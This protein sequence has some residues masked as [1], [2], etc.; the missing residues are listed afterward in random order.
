M[1]T[2]IRRHANIR[3]RARAYTHM[4][5]L[6]GV[7]PNVRRLIWKHG[8]LLICLVIPCLTMWL[9]KKPRSVMSLPPA[10]MYLDADIQNI[11]A[12]GQ[13]VSLSIYADVCTHVYVYRLLEVSLA[14]STCNVRMPAGESDP[15]LLFRAPSR[16]STRLQ[17]GLWRHSQ[18]AVEYLDAEMQDSSDWPGSFVQ[19]IVQGSALRHHWAWDANMCVYK[20]VC[21][22]MLL[23]NW[24][25][26][27]HSVGWMQDD[28]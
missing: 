25:K 20:H 24:A 4:C 15:S 27:L 1:H 16:R 22:Y 21:M 28:C 10:L 7:I 8:P 26:H 18:P 9:Q 2:H 5:M 6:F 12:I 23:G 3:T 13:V 19:G 14:L 11:P 17:E